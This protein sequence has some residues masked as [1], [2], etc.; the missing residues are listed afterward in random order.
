MD[1]TPALDELGWCP[2]GRVT[3]KPCPLCGGTRAVASL[4]RLDFTRAWGFNAFVV[5][6]VIVSAVIVG[7]C[8]SGVTLVQRRP[9]AETLSGLWLRLRPYAVSIR[10]GTMAVLVLAWAWNFGR[11]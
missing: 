4:L 6:S 7:I 1:L 8:L 11:W 9:L 2:F 3:G 10:P 5:S